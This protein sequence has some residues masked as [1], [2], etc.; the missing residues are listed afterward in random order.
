MVIGISFL[1]PRLVRLS[2]LMLA[3]PQALHCCL[4]GMSM[5]AGRDVPPEMALPSF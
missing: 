4:P 5:R 1:F 3:R 2:I